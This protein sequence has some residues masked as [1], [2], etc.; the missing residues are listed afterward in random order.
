MFG[1]NLK[2][3]HVERS[4]RVAEKNV[5]VHAAFFEKALASASEWTRF[6]DP[7]LIGVLALLGLG[8]AN[9]VS[10]ASPLW[11]HEEGW[12][13]GWLAAGGFVSACGFAVLTVAFAS[14]GLFPRTKRKAKDSEPSLYFFAGIGS[15]K[16]PGE[17]ERLVRN[18]SAQELESAIAHQAWE[19]SRIATKKH[20]WARWAY[21]AAILFL[22]AWTVARV[23]LSFVN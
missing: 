16:T 8:L 14:L 19:V 21:R 4:P 17:Y 9:I 22:V 12:V 5:R 11:A 7:K 20:F 1:R 6:A 18:K 13:W 23:A 15:I 3:P 2:H 10:Q